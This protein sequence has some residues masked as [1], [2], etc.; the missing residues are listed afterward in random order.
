VLAILGF[1]LLGVGFVL[2]PSTSQSPTPPYSEIVLN[3]TVPILTI[4]YRVTPA[5]P[6]VDDVDVEIFLN[7]TKL[8]SGI[9]GNLV[10]RLPIGFRFHT[11]PAKSCFR[12]QTPEGLYYTWAK[13]LTFDAPPILL[14]GGGMEHENTLGPEAVAHF[15]VNAHGFGETHNGSVASVALPTVQYHGPGSPMFTAGCYIPLASSYDWSSFP[16][17]YANDVRAVWPEQLAN[18]QALGRAAVGIDYGNEQR[19]NLYTFIAGALIGLAGSALLSSVQEA[20]HANDD[21]KP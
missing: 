5:S 20:L 15:S 12:K 14:P 8:P 3:S 13:L 1:A 6:S 9:V 11:C 17:V 7:G 10:L 4:N 21:Q 2:L 18:G 19:D 16:P